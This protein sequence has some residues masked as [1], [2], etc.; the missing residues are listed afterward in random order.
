MNVADWMTAKVETVHPRDTLAAAEAKMKNGHFRRVPVVDDG[1][2]LIG[3]LTERDLQEHKGYLPTTRVTVAMAENLVVIGPDDSIERAADI[4]LSR[5]IGGLPVVNS[6]GA[7]V[8]I[9]TETDVL[10]GLLRQV[11]A[12]RAG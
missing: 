8:G 10:V 6:N 5:K 7:L 2:A 12:A 1:G 9:I 11:Q 4:L 3:I